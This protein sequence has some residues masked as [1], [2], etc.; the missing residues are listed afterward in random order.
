MSQMGR[1]KYEHFMYVALGALVLGIFPSKVVT[2]CSSI[3]SM[4]EK[5]W[6]SKPFM[7]PIFEEEIRR[8]LSFGN[9]NSQVRHLLILAISVAFFYPLGWLFWVMLLGT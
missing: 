5:S 1:V 4:L 9:L 7:L 2:S 6:F 8:S 3:E